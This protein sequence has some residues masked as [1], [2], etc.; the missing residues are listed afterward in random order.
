[1]GVAAAGLIFAELVARFAF[2]LGD[3]PLFD[4]DPKIEYLLKPSCTY[5]SFGHSIQI[6]SHSMRSEDFPSRKSE[7]GEYR[8]MVIGDSIVNGGVR[9]DQSEL[10]TTLLGPMLEVSLG[11]RVVVGNISAGSWG[12]ANQAAYVEKYGIFDAD[13]VIIVLNSGDVN[14]VPGLEP[15]G[16]AW[17][18]TKPMLALQEPLRKAFERLTPELAIWSGSMKPASPPSGDRESMVGQSLRELISS[19]RPRDRADRKS[20]VKIGAVLYRS[21]SEIAAS[22]IPG[23]ERLGRVLETN[24]VPTWSSIARQAEAAN[25]TAIGDAQGGGPHPGFADDP[26]LFLPGD[27]VHASAAGQLRLAE[28]LR[29]VVIELEQRAQ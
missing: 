26:S 5:R 3:P 4:L 9:V 24:D 23:L 8:V 15:L 14:D 16:S 18:T 29:F 20:P 6:N 13:V 12:P 7:Q 17:P 19:I 2:G 21:R 22:S 10:A 25:A 27:D 28:L 11:E 1:M